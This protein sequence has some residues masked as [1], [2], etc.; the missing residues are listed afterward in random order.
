MSRTR[1][2]YK[3]KEPVAECLFCETKIP[4]PTYISDDTG[5]DGAQGGHCTRCGALF[6]TD[7][8]G[9]A[10]GQAVMDGLKLLAGGDEDAAIALRADIDY[11]L[12]GAG[13]N[14]RT[15][16]MDPKGSAKRYGQPKLWFFKS[17]A[18]E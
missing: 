8:T 13:Y 15:H 7:I 6:L 10:G 12:D 1:R 14:P 2:G 5:P 16:S 4:K 11:K 18:E 9:R 3:R 17:L